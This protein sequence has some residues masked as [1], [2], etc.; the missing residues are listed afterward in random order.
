M[1][2]R[3]LYLIHNP[4]FTALSFTSIPSEKLISFFFGVAECLPQCWQH[5]REVLLRQMS[6]LDQMLFLTQPVA[7]MGIEPENHYSQSPGSN[8]KATVAPNYANHT[9]SGVVFL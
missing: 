6:N 8:H 2:A 1:L 9:K 5:C 3:Q 7:L 4:N